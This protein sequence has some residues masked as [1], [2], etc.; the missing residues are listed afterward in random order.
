VSHALLAA[1]TLLLWASLVYRVVRGH[2]WAFQTPA[3]RAGGIALL[4]LPLYLGWAI[5]TQR[6][7]A[8]WFVAAIALGLLSYSTIVQPPTFSTLAQSSLGARLSAVLE[9]AGGAFLA[10]AASA[11]LPA[12]IGSLA[13]VA[14]RPGTNSSPG[15]LASEGFVR[16]AL[17]CLALSLAVD[18]WWLQKVGLGNTQDAQQAGIAV[19]W[20]VYFVALRLRTQ[21]D[22]RGWPWAAVITVGFGCALPILLNVPWL[23]TPLAL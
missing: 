20:M 6:Q 7:E 22:W 17:L 3:D 8:G 13:H 15:D 16:A 4:V 12:L 18:T 10:L 21:P 2:G 5:A 23:E 11:S 19:T 9:L 14:R 1:S